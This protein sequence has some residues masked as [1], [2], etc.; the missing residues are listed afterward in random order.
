MRPPSAEEYNRA[1]V[2]KNDTKQTIRIP[3]LNCEN[4]GI[5]VPE[6]C[7]L[8]EVPGGYRVVADA[9][10]VV[11]AAD[12]DSEVDVGP[13]TV[14]TRTKSTIVGSMPL[15][16]PTLHPSIIL[17]GGP[18]SALAAVAR[19]LAKQMRLNKVITAP[20]YNRYPPRLD[21]VVCVADIHSAP[22]AYKVLMRI[23]FKDAEKLVRGS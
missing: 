13:Y 5:E 6:G 23:S 10:P 20:D 17:V 14:P 12:P 19:K 21:Y 16:R 8:E 3:A 1:F 11:K 15:Q 9:P 4:Y 7:H 22:A 2:V 18:P